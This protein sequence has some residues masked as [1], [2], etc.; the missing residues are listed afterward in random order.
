M[1]KNIDMKFKGTKGKTTLFNE[2]FENNHNIYV[3]P[4]S[5]SSSNEILFANA[6]GNTYQESRAN[7]KLISCAREMLEMLD[8][9]TTVYSADNIEKAKLLIKKATTI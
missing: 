7:A 4:I 3:Q 5:I 6:Y 9:L 8:L 2:C 1:V